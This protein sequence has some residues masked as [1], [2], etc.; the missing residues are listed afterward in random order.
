M[1]VATGA[2]GSVE[3]S[4]VNGMVISDF[5]HHMIFGS[6]Y[7]RELWVDGLVVE[8]LL[9]LCHMSAGGLNKNTNVQKCSSIIG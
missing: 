9:H 4:L 5:R 1:P 7:K 2:A 6:D 3:G 8:A